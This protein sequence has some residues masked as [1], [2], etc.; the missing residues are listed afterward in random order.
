MLTSSDHKGNDLKSCRTFQPPVTIEEGK[1]EYAY[2][3]RSLHIYNGDLVNEQYRAYQDALP[4]DSI[5]SCVSASLTSSTTHRAFHSQNGDVRKRHVMEM[6]VIL[7]IMDGICV[8]QTLELA[9]LR[10]NNFVQPEK[11]V[12]GNAFSHSYGQSPSHLSSIQQHQIGIYSSYIWNS[13]TALLKLS[14]HSARQ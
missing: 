7:A 2:G 14:K 6:R 13:Q 10:D 5:C 4:P 8:H 3:R 9:A 1:V 12:L 11:A